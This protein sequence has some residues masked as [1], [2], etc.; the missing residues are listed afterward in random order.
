MKEETVEIDGRK[1]HL[2]ELKLAGICRLYK[3][4]NFRGI[5]QLGPE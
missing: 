1:L 2:D 5:F 3:I 4:P